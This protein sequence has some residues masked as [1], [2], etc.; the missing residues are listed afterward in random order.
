MTALFAQPGGFGAPGRCSGGSPGRSRGPSRRSAARPRRRELLDAPEV[1]PPGAIHAP[2]CTSPAAR[3]KQEH[4]DAARVV[5]GVGEG[6]RRIG[7]ELVDREVA[8]ARR[9]SARRAPPEW[10]TRRAPRCVSRRRGARSPSRRTRWPTDRSRA[11]RAG[12]RASS[13][14]GQRARRSAPKRDRRG[15][16]RAAPGSSRSTVS[17]FTRVAVVGTRCWL[18][19]I[20]A[21]QPRGLDVVELDARRSHVPALDQRRRPPCRVAVVGRREPGSVATTHASP[22]NTSARSSSRRAGTRSARRRHRGL[23]TPSVRPVVGPV[24]RSDPAAERGEVLV[25]GQ[26]E[27]VVERELS[28]VGVAL[29]RQPAARQQRVLAR[30]SRCR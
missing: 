13:G 24:D 20:A 29:R 3:Q 21:S 12:R 8:E 25:G 18:N 30:R 22:T 9:Q 15:A 28:L 19:T 1:R 23:G 6:L 27:L 10:R 26:D 14:G 17:M 11:G 7:R 16:D 5:G 2:V 4:P